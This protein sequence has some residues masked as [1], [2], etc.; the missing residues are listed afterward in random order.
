MEETFYAVQQ[1][2][3][4]RAGTLPTKVSTLDDAREFINMLKKGSEKLG[5]SDLE[6]EY[7]VY[8]VKEVTY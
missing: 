1:V 3:N 5:P 8:E 2:F 4:G 6:I 7:H